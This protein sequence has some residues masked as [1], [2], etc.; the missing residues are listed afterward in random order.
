M[1][2][3]SN[4]FN[5]ERRK[6][7]PQLSRI[8]VIGRYGPS[9]YEPRQGVL[10]APAGK[11]GETMALEV[12]SI[13]IHLTLLPAAATARQAHAAIDRAKTARVGSVAKSF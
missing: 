3:R 12:D 13:G 5:T 2:V 6:R 8:E 10:I 7:P 1:A 4:W 11:D 9:I